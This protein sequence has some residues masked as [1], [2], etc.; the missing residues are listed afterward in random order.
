MLAPQEHAPQHVDRVQAQG[1]V[2]D[3]AQE[4]LGHINPGAVS[5]I[6]GV[7]RSSQGASAHACD[8]VRDDLL[9]HKCARNAQFDD[10]EWS[11]AR[12][13]NADLVKVN[14]QVLRVFFFE[15]DGLA[16][17]AT[18]RSCCLTAPESECCAELCRA[19]W[20]YSSAVAL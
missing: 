20:L 17:G 2:R 13:G 4:G 1:A 5:H 18:L 8:D 16:H 12:I 9:L 11:T 14:P 6:E 7:R 3:A 10:D 15:K 19:Q